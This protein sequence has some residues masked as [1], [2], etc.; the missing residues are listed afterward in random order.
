MDKI[1]QFV[2]KVY[3]KVRPSK[4]LYRYGTIGL[5]YFDDRTRKEKF[6]D[7]ID[8]FFFNWQ[9]NIRYRRAYRKQV[10]HSFFDYGLGRVVS[11]NDEIKA[12]EKEGYVY[13][14]DAEADRET[15]RRRRI[16][17][18]ERRQRIEKHF[19]E[20]FARIKA[21]NSN[22]YEQLKNRTRGN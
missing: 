3:K 12:K 10:F 2:Y 7:Y 22:Y 15:A 6:F 4:R 13:I 11:S 16:N 20:G 8:E 1:L 19:S 21:G 5:K 18:Q 14:S 17:K 9:Q